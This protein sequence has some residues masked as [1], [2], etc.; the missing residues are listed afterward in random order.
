MATNKEIAR[1]FVAEYLA[2]R[3]DFAE[4]VEYVDMEYPYAEE[5]DISYGE[6]WTEVIGRLDTVEQRYADEDE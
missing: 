3:P 4:M 5:E 6:I 2:N 1:E